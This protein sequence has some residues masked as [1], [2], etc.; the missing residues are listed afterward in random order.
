MV[1]RF[2][3]TYFSK[4]TSSLDGRKK[5]VIKDYGLGNLLQ[6]DRCI[7]PLPFARWIA[8][9]VKTNTGDIVVNNHCIPLSPESVHDV[10]GTTLGGRLI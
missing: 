3:V 8:D 6:F 5:G 7:I 4:I 10:I 9:R 2:N 1:T